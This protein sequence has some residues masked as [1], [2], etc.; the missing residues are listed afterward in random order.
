MAGL[1]KISVDGNDYLWSYHFDD[2]DY[3]NASQLVVKSAD[4]KGSLI[5]LFGER[6]PAVGYCP[7]NRGVEA[8]L[9]GKQV[10]INLNQPRFVAEILTH[11]LKEK[12]MDRLV[13]TTML[14]N[15]IEILRD[16]G[17]IFDYEKT[18]E[19]DVLKVEPT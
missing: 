2:Y 1:R 16:M 6:N 17:Y 7:F 19:P 11:I 15:G 12:K 5:V 4:K 18:W 3:Q 9:K 14:Q 8:T 10:T 13:G